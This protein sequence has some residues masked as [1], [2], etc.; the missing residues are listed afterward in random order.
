MRIIGIIL[1]LI[2]I[3]LYFFWLQ[4][5][6]KKPGIKA[7]EVLGV[8]TFDIIVKGVYSP[9]VLNA[10]A[11]TPVR[12][13]FSRQESTECSR[14]VNFPDFKIRQE[15]PEGKTVAVEFIPQQKG[16]YIFSCDMSMYQGRLIVE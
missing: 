12:I 11:K 16:E 3:G 15:L 10:K 1:I 7:K 5:T 14:F 8:Q 9:N 2:V 4:Y 6:R 13:N